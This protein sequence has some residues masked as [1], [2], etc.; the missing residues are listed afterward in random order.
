MELHVVQSGE[1][2]FSIAQQYGVTESSIIYNNELPD[3]RN[4]VEGQVLVILFPEQVHTVQEGETLQSIARRYG[5]TLNSLFRNNIR[6]KGSENIFP[7][8]TIVIR[9]RDVRE[10]EMEVN[11]YAY[12]WINTT[13][14]RQTLPY[15]T[16]LTPFT[17]GITYSGGLV[18]LND[19]ALIAAANQYGTA[20]LMHLST[21]T[22]QGNF[23]N[24]LAS[25]VLNNF[26]V[27]NTLIEN[28]LRTMREKGYYGLDIDF[29]FVFAE[30]ATLYVAFIQNATR[31][32]NAQGYE[33]IVALAPKTSATQKGLLYEGHDYRGIGEAANAVLLMTYEWGYTYGR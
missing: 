3:P 23:S 18:D 15:L 19:E 24:E 29:E 27:Q 8:E 2:V 1:T 26:A 5:V 6:L 22:E 25:H 30:E 32:L 31:R 12:P 14:L 33:V 17:Y 9:Y 16:Y 28:I 13:L 20:P 11:A 10:G 21:L 4:L 7:G